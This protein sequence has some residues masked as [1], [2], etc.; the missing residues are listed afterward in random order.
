MFGGGGGGGGFEFQ[1][2]DDGGM[3]NFGGGGGFPGHGDF[4]GGRSGGHKQRNHP[5]LFPKNNDHGIAPLGKAK[6]PDSTSKFLWLVIFYSN[7][8]AQCQHAKS[9]LEQLSGKTNGAFKIGAVNCKR[10]KSETSFC[11]QNGVDLNDLPAFGMVVDGQVSLL[12]T[13][14]IPNAKQLYD[15]AIDHF[16]TYTIQNINHPQHLEERLQQAILNDDKKVGAILLI[17]DK[18]KTSSLYLSLSYQFRQHFVFGESRGKNL[19]LGKQFNVETY[20]TLCAIIKQKDNSFKIELTTNL[21][22]ESIEKWLTRLVG[23]PTKS[24]EKSKRKRSR[25][26]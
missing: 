17:T 26:N 16:P 23:K 21:K 10:N 12:E 25:R 3:P 8:D 2:E 22:R 18:Y 11:K 5:E 13:S 14:S 24:N 20:P 1:F 9:T 7:D 4:F 15:F 19:S 6:F